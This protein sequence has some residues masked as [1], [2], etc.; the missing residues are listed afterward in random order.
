MA[1]ASASREIFWN[2]PHPSVM[3]LLFF[4]SM[5]ILG[6]GVYRHVRVWQAGKADNKRFSR[7]FK[8]LWAA[9]KALFLQRKTFNRAYPGIFHALIFYSF[10]VLFITTLLI[11]FDTHFGTTLFEGC[12]Y[13]AFS[14][15]CELAGVFML[16]GIGM[17][18]WRRLVLKPNTLDR[19]GMDLLMLLLLAGIV[20]TGFLVE[21]GRLA[22]QE[23][24]REWVSPI[25]EMVSR[26]VSGAGNRFHFAVW[27][28]HTLLVM[29]WIA[30]IPFTKFFHLLLLPVNAGFGKL[31]PAGELSRIDLEALMEQ[32]DIDEAELNFGVGSTEDF[33]WKQRMDLDACVD[34]G[35]CDA[36]CPAL[37]AGQ[38]LSPKSLIQE[39][40]EL[41]RRTESAQTDESETISTDIVGN[42]FDMD[43]IWLC[44][45]CM[46]CVEICPA[47]IQHVDLFVDIRRNEIAM[48]GRL[49][50]HA[51]AALKTMES[52]GNPFAPQK[53]RIE[54]TEGLDVPVIAPGEGCDILYWTGCLTA[55]DSAKHRIAV[56]L[57]TLLGYA[58]VDYGILGFDEQCCGDPAR[59]IGD[60]HMFQL[61][62]KEQAAQLNRREFNQLLV[63]CPHGY[64]VLKDEYPQFGGEYDVIH[65][66][67]LLYR[68]V[69]EGKLRLKTPPFNRVVAYHDPCYLA[70]YQRMWETPRKLIDAVPG[71]ERVEM[72]RYGKESFCCG[73]GGGHL[74]MD[75]KEGTR[76]NAMRVQQALEAG[77]ETLITSCPFCLHMLDD[78]IKLLDAEDRITVSDIASFLIECLDR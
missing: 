72:R 24:N 44:R 70:R 38:P 74:W 18:L 55:L 63:S 1:Y 73:G 71:T 11:L 53:D 23:Q 78:G 76:L 40:R 48:K 64:T 35:R 28:G 13:I 31:G 8:R 3:Y 60:E 54:W 14:L 49:P 46:A 34:C 75:F 22:I 59:V 52:L 42:A 9:N 33:T 29:V 16:I 39:S 57:C 15:G 6:Y 77:A 62:A 21:G 27:W 65:Y 5:C 51:A 32:D 12:V 30:V 17:A 67:R 69:R 36:V 7:A 61:I 56:D 20:I 47:F 10:L 68:L 37:N 26:L 25:G 4:I 50:T 58:S 19:S 41:L 43:F 66:T 45:T 2:I